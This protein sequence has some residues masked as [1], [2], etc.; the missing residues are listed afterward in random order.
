MERFT[1]SN[2]TRESLLE[3]LNSLAVDEKSHFPGPN[4]EESNW[5]A[6]SLAEGL[7]KPNPQEP[8]PLPVMENQEPKILTMISQVVDMLLCRD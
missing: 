2:R 4:G 3:S 8:K 6:P 1:Q 7:N 5:E